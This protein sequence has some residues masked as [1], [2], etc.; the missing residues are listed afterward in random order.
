MDNINKKSAENLK[1][2]ILKDAQEETTKEEPKIVKDEVVEEVKKVEVESSETKKAP[3]VEEEELLLGKF[4]TQ[5][6]LVKAYQESEKKITELSQKKEEEPVID[7]SPQSDLLYES[8][9]GT[10]TDKAPTVVNPVDS[11]DSEVTAEEN[12]QEIVS[13]R[14]KVSNLEKVGQY[15][16]LSQQAVT[17]RIEAAELLRDDPVLPYTK[18]V[19]SELEK[20]IFK[21][22]PQ[23]KYQRGGYKIAHEMLKGRK[24]DGLSK[25][26]IDVAVQ[27]ALDKAEKNKIAVVETPAKSDPDPEFDFSKLSTEDQRKQLKKNFGEAQR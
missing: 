8:I 5:E 11:Y 27:E 2:Q 25:A 13:L 14:E 19:E 1:Q 3:K 10:S 26:K 6:D 9:F 23:L 21:E 17:N 24:A 4:K 20:T 15:Q 18:E 12:N 7:N 22:L 16:L